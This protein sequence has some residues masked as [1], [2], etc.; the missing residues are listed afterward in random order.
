MRAFCLRDRV[1]LLSAAGTSLFGIQ[2]FLWMVF[3]LC[4]KNGML[5]IERVVGRI[6]S[7][8]LV[9]QVYLGLRDRYVLGG[10]SKTD[11]FHIDS[12]NAQQ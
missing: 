8:R 12:E 9:F 2:K 10:V 6:L 7:S 5:S 1:I 3:L 11:R 4:S